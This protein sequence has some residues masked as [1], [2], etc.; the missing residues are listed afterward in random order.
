MCVC[1]CVY[2]YIYNGTWVKWRLVFM[3][4]L[5]PPRQQNVKSNLNFFAGIYL[6]WKTSVTSEKELSPTD[7]TD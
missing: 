1:V 7:F 3:G 6:R 5:L 4:K 2:I